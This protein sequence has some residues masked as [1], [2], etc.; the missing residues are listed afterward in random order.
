VSRDLPLVNRSD[1]KGRARLVPIPDFQARNLGPNPVRTMRVLGM[2]RAGHSWKHIVEVGR[3][4]GAWTEQE[5]RNIL[6]A[7]GVPVPE[8]PHPAATPGRVLPLPHQ[9]LV[10]A[11]AMTRAW[12]N[13]EIAAH[14]KLPEGTVKAYVRQIIAAS[15]C[16]DRIGF[17]VAVLTGQ[18]DLRD[19]DEHDAG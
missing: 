10:V 14:H 19:Q 3:Y 12:T 13:A 1:A 8:G 4:Q 17:V 18:I 5:A 16:R 9:Q 6:A 15:E 11:R 2:V 7:N